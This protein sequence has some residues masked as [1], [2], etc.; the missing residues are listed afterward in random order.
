MTNTFRGNPEPVP[1]A[2]QLAVIP[3]LAAIDGFLRQGREPAGLRLTM[4][5]AVNREGQVYLQQVC[6]YI[7]EEGLEWRG[8]VG[9]TYPVSEGIMGAAFKTRS[10]WRTKKF[11][12]LRELRSRLAIDIKKTKDG[13]DPAKVEVSFLAVPFLGPQDQPVLILYADCNELNFFAEDKRVSSIAAMSKGFCKLFDTLQAEPFLNLRNFPLQDGQPVE[14]E[15][16][17]YPSVQE[18][19]KKIAPPR[20]GIVRSFNYEAAAA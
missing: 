19:V 3:F 7:R 15:P 12:T 9:R 16:T 2:S 8:K 20:F 10:I 17:V 4:H 1:S 5:R 11:S 14:D 6:G 18:A 13:R